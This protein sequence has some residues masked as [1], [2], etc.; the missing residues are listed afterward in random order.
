MGNTARGSLMAK[1]IP[2]VDFDR[3][4]SGELYMISGFVYKADDLACLRTYMDYYKNLGLGYKDS[5]FLPETDE[6]LGIIRFFPETYE[7]LEIPYGKALGGSLEAPLPFTGNGFAG[8]AET[9][10]IIP[11]WRFTFPAM[12][13]DGAELYIAD[14]NGGQILWS[15]FNSRE[16]RFIRLE[17]MI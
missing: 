16:N 12:I 9:D 4:M 13:T 2:T 11:E 7:N 3:Y 14:R 17:D 8:G 5:H 10:L 15:V 6:F 1:V